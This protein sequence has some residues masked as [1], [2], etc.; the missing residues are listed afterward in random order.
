MFIH[1]TPLL[2]MEEPNIYHHKVEYTWSFKKGNA[3]VNHYVKGYAI[4]QYN[5]I[6][7]LNL[8][9]VNYSMAIKRYGL[10]GRKFFNF[11]VTKIYDSKIVG[12]VN[13]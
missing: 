7:E 13:K 5:T 1:E 8:D 2:I 3:K 9:N 11:Q 10:V 4:S 12:K 6:E